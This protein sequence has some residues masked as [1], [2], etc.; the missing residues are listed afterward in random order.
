MWCAA[1]KPLST[2]PS[3]IAMTVVSA[4]TLAVPRAEARVAATSGPTTSSGIRTALW[5]II[6]SASA[7][8]T[9]IPTPAASAVLASVRS[10]SRLTGV[11]LDGSGGCAGATAGRRWVQRRP[12]CG[13]GSG[14]E[15]L[16]AARR[17]ER[18]VE[19]LADGHDR[20]EGH[21]LAD[22]RGHVVEVA[23][24]ALGEDH[25]GQSG[26]VRG[27]HLLLQAADRQHAALERHLARHADGVL[28]RPAAQQRGERGRHRDAGARAVLRDRAR[29]HVDVELAL[30]ER[31]VAD[32]EL[33]RVGAHVRERDARGLLHD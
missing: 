32:A 12:G 6:T 29:G 16:A 23:A 33:G 10:C 17:L 13:G 5:P 31:L 25:V 20:V 4:A 24:V 27:E 30:L 26:R 19:H 9:V 11:M 8:A 22:V 15:P 14:G 7:R 28:H 18:D 1:N 2:G 3:A 21:L